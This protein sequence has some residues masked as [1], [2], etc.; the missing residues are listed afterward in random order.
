MKAVNKFLYIIEALMML[1]LAFVENLADY[2]GGV[3]RHIYFYKI[4]YSRLFYNDKSIIIQLLI[5]M[6]IFFF[7]V[8]IFKKS[9]NDKRKAGF[10]GYI[11]YTILFIIAFNIPMTQDLIVYVYLLMVLQVCIF[12]EGIRIIIN[13]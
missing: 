2:K 3:M 9:V 10:I 4:K 6:L 8:H 1:A 12:I 11:I 5:I 13:K 7:L